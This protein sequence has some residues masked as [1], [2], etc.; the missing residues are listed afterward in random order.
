MTKTKKTELVVWTAYGILL[1]F[2]I[3]AAW[4]CHLI[5]LLTP[6]EMHDASYDLLD[7]VEHEHLQDI[8][9]V[10]SM[11]TRHSRNI[12]IVLSLAW[13]LFAGGVLFVYT[14]ERKSNRQAERRL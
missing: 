6:M 5:H 3:A 13:A 11:V 7:K 4:F 8:F 12:L 2:S 1:V 14:K 9:D 10:G